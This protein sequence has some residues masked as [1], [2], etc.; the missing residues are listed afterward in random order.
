MS[1]VEAIRGSYSGL[2]Q[3][4]KVVLIVSSG[5]SLYRSIDLARLLIRHGGD[6]HVFMTPKAARLVSPD[7][8]HWATGNKP[9]AA[10]TGGAEHVEICAKAD[11]AIVAPATANTIAKMSIGIA[12]NAAL[13]CLLA[14]SQAKKVVVPAMNLSMWDTPQVREALERL[15]RYATIVEPMIEEGKA[16]YPPVEEVVEFAIDATAPA[17]YSGVGVLVTAGPTREYID[18]IKYVTTPSSGLTGYY[19]AR[20]AKARG[21]QVTLVTGPTGLRP[22]PG[23]EVVRVTSVLEMYEE[24]AKRAREHQVFIFAAAPLDFYVERKAGGKLDSSLE[25]HQVSLRRA[26]KIAQDVKRLNPEAVVVGFK[27]EFKLKEEE[28]I[29]KARERLLEGGWEMAL[30]HDVSQMGF[31][32]P[33]DEYIVVTRGGVERLGPAHKRELARVVLTRLAAGSHLKRFH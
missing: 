14:A 23:V 17:D 2:L 21:A 11:V 15:S 20:E 9:V 1:E 4:R 12:D 26:P 31:G 8:F 29:S 24:V 6:V 19:F 13:T 5:V 10:L 22:P 32:T 33:R 30:A 16:K 25:R 27:A 28:I 18:D 7:L 3:G